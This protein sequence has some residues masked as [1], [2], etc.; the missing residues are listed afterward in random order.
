MLFSNLQ[1]FILPDGSLPRAEVQRLKIFK[2]P[3]NQEM[4]GS[5]DLLAVSQQDCSSEADC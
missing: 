4:Q 1:I 5:I 2:A 3:L